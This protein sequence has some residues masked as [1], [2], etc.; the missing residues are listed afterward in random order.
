MLDFRVPSDEPGV[1]LPLLRI[2]KQSKL[3]LPQIRFIMLQICEAI[4]YLHAKNIM[5]KD[6][7]PENVMIDPLTLQVKVIDYGFAKIHEG[8]CTG[9]MATRWYRPM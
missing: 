6:M 2:I 3:A 4:A 5:H 1:V 8:E 7:K 9:Y